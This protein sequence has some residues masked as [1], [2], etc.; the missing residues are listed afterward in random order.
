M[1][2]TSG[3]TGPSFHAVA[4]YAP[5]SIGLVR[6]VVRRS[7]ITLRPVTGSWVRASTRT[8][9]QMAPTGRPSCQNVRHLRPAGRPDPRYWRI[10][11]AWPP[12]RSRPS[13]AAGSRLAQSTGRRKAPSIERAAHR[14]PWRSSAAPSLPKTTPSS[15]RGSAAGAPEPGLGGE[16][17]LVAGRCEVVP[18]YGDLGDVDVVVG[19][20]DEDTC[21]AHRPTL[22][23]RR[24]GVGHKKGR[25]APRVAHRGGGHA[26]RRPSGG[27]PGWSEGI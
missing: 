20:R 11:G 17:H 7:A 19:Q 26:D 3:S 18:G 13:K 12:G 6:H 24:A 21:A 10:P 15:S 25:V 2:D 16:H 4:R 27:C 23:R 5:R 1:R 8:P 14:R 22:R 9:W